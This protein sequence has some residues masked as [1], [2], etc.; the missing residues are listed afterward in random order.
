MTPTELIDAARR[1]YNAESDTFFS[2][3]ELLGL[4]YQASKELAVKAYVIENTFTTTSTASTEEYAFPTNMFAIK[5]V[6]YNGVKLRKI[7]FREDDSVTYSGSTTNAEGTPRW[8]TIWNNTI[9]LT[10][11]PDTSSLTIKVWGYMVP[12]SFTITGSLEIPE[13]YHWDVV[14]FMLSR[15]SA[16][17][18]NDG[19]SQSYYSL[20]QGHV[21]EAIRNER[22]RRRADGNAIV[23]NEDDLDVTVLGA[24]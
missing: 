2:E 24:T 12:D 22:R 5:R 19:L 16:K 17:D 21:N 6:T 4:I 7:S 23:G 13:R 3:A 11:T 14:D 18:G 20:W 15:M 1:Q 8:Y 10:P 9:A